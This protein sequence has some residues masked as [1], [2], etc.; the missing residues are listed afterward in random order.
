MERSPLQDS[1][2]SFKQKVFHGHKEQQEAFAQDRLLRILSGN[3]AGV[4]T[5]MRRMASQRNLK[6]EALKTV[7]LPSA[8][9]SPWTK[10]SASPIFR[11]A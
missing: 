7:R 5:G 8:G 10:I 4:I 9:N 2:S 1:R 3:V 11:A 6:G